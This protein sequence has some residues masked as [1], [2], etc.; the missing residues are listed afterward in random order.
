MNDALEWGFRMRTKDDLPLAT[1][2][3]KSDSLKCSLGML[4]TYL[5]QD[6]IT[7]PVAY[8]YAS[9]ASDGFGILRHRA[10]LDS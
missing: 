4:D 6:Y 7:L 9:S 5:D 1:Q 3:P 8:C 10:V 2:G